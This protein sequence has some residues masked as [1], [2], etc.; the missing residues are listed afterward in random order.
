MA[1]IAIITQDEMDGWR[2]KEE[3]GRRKSILYLRVGFSRNLGSHLTASTI[4]PCAL[5]LSSSHFLAFVLL[6]VSILVVRTN[7]KMM[8]FHLNLVLLIHV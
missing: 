2:E 3:G 1:W 8:A 6:S 5:V 7:E 4:P